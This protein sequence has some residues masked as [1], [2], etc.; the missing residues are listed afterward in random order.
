MQ[1]RGRPPLYADQIHAV[2]EAQGWVAIA[3]QQN[4]TA[5]SGFRGRYPGYDFRCVP[6]DG[7]GKPFIL[8]VKRG[9]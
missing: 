8:E 9:A 3:Q 6:N 1:N 5:P 4:R 7:E 2:T